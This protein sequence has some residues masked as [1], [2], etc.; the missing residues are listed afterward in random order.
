MSFPPLL[1]NLALKDADHT[2][3]GTAQ[4]VVLANIVVQHLWMKVLLSFVPLRM[5]W[6]HHLNHQVL[7]GVAIEVQICREVPIWVLTV[8]HLTID[9]HQIRFS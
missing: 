9:C 5:C 6:L 2:N 4:E 7:P 8:S 3:G 1:H